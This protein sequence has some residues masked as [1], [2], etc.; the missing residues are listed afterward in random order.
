MIKSIISNLS[1][2]VTAGLLFI[3]TGI[4]ILV[5]PIKD[6]NSYTPLYGAPLSSQ[7]YQTLFSPSIIVK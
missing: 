5:L 2:P 6:Y 3:I 4:C 1:F 7:E